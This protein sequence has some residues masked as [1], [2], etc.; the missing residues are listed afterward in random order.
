MRYIEDPLTCSKN[1]SAGIW[2]VLIFLV[3][4][5]NTLRLQLALGYGRELR[6]KH[7]EH[8]ARCVYGSKPPIS[9]L[10]SDTAFGSFRFAADPH[11]L[12]PT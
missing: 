4:L 7:A 9:D 6:S 12:W 10:H 1:C 8:C 3:L 2:K 5:P 11:V